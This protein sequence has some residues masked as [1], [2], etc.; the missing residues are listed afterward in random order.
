VGSIPLLWLGGGKGEGLG[1]GDLGVGLGDFLGKGD[2]RADACVGEGLDTAAGTADLGT[3]A[4][5][6]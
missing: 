5:L 2:A 3:N 4:G 1:L 6:A